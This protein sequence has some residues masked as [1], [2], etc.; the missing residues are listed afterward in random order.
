MTTIVL[1]LQTFHRK[2]HFIGLSGIFKG[3]D[4]TQGLWESV[5]Y[6]Q[7]SLRSVYHVRSLDVFRLNQ[8]KEKVHVML[9]HDWPRGITNYGNVDNLL[10]RKPFFE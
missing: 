6:S 3:H 2:Y 9:S 5:P 4:Y 1:T 10:K 8:L 7:N